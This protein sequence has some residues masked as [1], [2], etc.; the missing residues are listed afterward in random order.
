MKLGTNTITNCKI[1]STQVNEVR[2]GSTLIWSNAPAYDVDAMAFIT[3]YSITDNTQ[4]TAI[5]NAVL[6]LKAGTLWTKGDVILPIV[7]GNATSHRG[8]LKNA[9]NGVTW[10]GGITHDIS[11]VLF[12]GINGYGNVEWI[13]P[14]LY[15][16]TACESTKLPITGNEGWS[17]IF[18]GSRVFGMQLRKNLL[19]L[20]TVAIGLNN[21][22]AINL[23]QPIGVRSSIIES[24]SV[25]GGKHY[26][27]STLMYQSTPGANPSGFNYFIGA[28]NNSN[29]PILF[30]NRPQ[31][32]FYFG[33]ALT[34]TEHTELVGIINTFNTT[35][36]R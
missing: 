11:G 8:N 3:A 2:I 25:N 10:N 22:G 13:A 17:G 33:T 16:R 4:K 19:N 18:S 27:N 26:N 35:L 28:L 30:N 12:N 20:E 23:I 21:L 6:A 29:S 5:N 1:G 15:S 7:G 36:G 9:T 14:N 32:F 31:D 24:S 34:A